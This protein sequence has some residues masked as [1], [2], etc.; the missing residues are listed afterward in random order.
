MG[1]TPP[2]ECAHRLWSFSGGP[3]LHPAPSLVVAWTTLCPLPAVSVQ[4]TT[5]LS[6]GLSSEIRVSAPSPCMHQ[7]MHVLGWG[8]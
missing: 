4:P 5:V 2:F 6:L 7:Q 8:L 3:G 1:P